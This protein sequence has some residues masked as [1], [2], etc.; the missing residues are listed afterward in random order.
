MSFMRSFWRSVVLTLAVMVAITVPVGAQ[1]S[2]S[3]AA[4]DPATLGVSLE[5]IQTKL[6]RLPS[7]DE[8]SS[9]LRLDFYVEV[10][11]EAPKID[12]FQ[13]FDLD[14]APIAHGVP[15]HSQMMAVMSPGRLAPILGPAMDLGAG[16]D[17][18]LNGR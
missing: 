15:T 5:R 16:V 9:L 10:Y 3:E 14:N 8:V 18:L 1:D 6:D 4:F 7:R 17:W 13:G 2:E 11:A 12:Y